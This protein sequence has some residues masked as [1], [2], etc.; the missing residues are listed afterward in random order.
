MD[1]REVTA[2]VSRQSD[3]YVLIGGH[4]ISILLNRARATVDVDVIVPSGQAGK[5][6]AAL[7]ECYPDLEL[8]DLAAR[9]EGD[10]IRLGL[11]GMAEEKEGDR[12]DVIKG[13]GVFALALKHRQRVRC[14]ASHIWIP[15]FEAA[16]GMKYAAIIS[17]TRSAP[18]KEK[19]KADF[20]ALVMA[21]KDAKLDFAVLES[22]A[23]IAL[24]GSGGY[25][26]RLAID[27]VK[28]GKSPF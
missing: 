17:P 24:A 26:I 20:M 21:T 13:V 19:D 14:G 15:S 3:G 28:R 27:A 6:A 7:S 5:V 25:E 10:S 2:A 9:G 12:I 8:V 4:A 11:P 1:P 22:F 23:D 16:I 18:D